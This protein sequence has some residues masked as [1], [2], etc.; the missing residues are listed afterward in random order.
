MCANGRP[1]IRAAREARWD[2]VTLAANYGR[3]KPIARAG[4]NARGGKQKTPACARVSC[5]QPGAR[6]RTRTSTKLPPLAPEASASTNSA[7]RAGGS[8]AFCVRANVL[9]TPGLHTPSTG[10]PVIS[11]HEQTT[12][13]ARQRPRQENII[14]QARQAGQSGLPRQGAARRKTGRQWQALRCCPSGPEASRLACRIQ[15]W[16]VP[17]VHRP[18]RVHT[19][20]R[21]GTAM[22]RTPRAKHSAMKSPSPV[23]R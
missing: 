22:T 12:Q 2:A 3:F 11:G 23:A 16:H 19:P 1:H 13:Q 20:S 4:L 8:R 14:R 9:S 5:F 10:G 15:A 6:K 7:I 21:T 18:R 17:W